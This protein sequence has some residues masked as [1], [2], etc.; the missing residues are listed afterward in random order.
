MSTKLTAARIATAAGCNTVICRA[1]RPENIEKILDGEPNGTVFYHHPKALK[2]A[3]V[4][5]FSCH[6][7]LRSW[8]AA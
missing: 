4:H 7:W 8:Q 6:Q 5:D 1:S 2:Y 3:T